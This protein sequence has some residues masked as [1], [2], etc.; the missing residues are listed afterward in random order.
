M[1]LGYLFFSGKG[2][3]NRKPYWIGTLVMIVMSLLLGM[4][5]GTFLIMS[6]S[7][8]L[9]A[10]ILSGL[11]TLVPAYFLMAK[12]LQDRGRPGAMAW[13]LL[14]PIMIQNVQTL[15]G[16]LGGGSD[17]GTFDVV[18]GSV[19]MVIGLW[20]FIEL[21]FLRGTPGPN[22]FGPDPL[23]PNRAAYPSPRATQPMDWT[24]PAPD[25]PSAP[26]PTGPR[27][28]RG[29]GPSPGGWNT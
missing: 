13:L 18:F 7:I 24:P 11:V 29:D 10:V 15:T 17:P 27:V 22:R 3:I 19:I 9:I 5:A 2:R 8:G 4:A 21:G 1:N 26:S 25:A 23:D 16:A 12:R 20:F 28:P 6:P 14:V